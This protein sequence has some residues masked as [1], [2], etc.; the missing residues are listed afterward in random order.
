MKQSLQ[1]RI[2]QQLT[3]TPQLQ[4]AIRLLQLSTLDLHQEIQ[5][6]LDSNLMLEIA[7]DEPAQSDE[8]PDEKRTEL[9][10][11]TS[12]GSQT[13]IPDE[14]P[15][16]SSWEDVYDNVQ[17]SGSSTAAPE[18]QDFETYRC[19]SPTLV[20]HL[21]WQ[22]E[23]AKFSEPDRAIAIAIIDS[24]NSEGY[25]TSTIEDIHL[26]LL[27]QMEAL[28]IEEVRAVLHRVQN[29]DPPGVAAADLGDCLRIQLC[30]LPDDVVWKHTAIELVTHFLDQLAAQN[31]PRLKRLLDLNDEELDQ[32]IALIRSLNP[33]PGSAIENHESQYVIPDVFVAKNKD[34]WQVSLNP[35]IAPKLRV[36]PYYSSMIKRADN[37][38]DNACLRNHLQEARWFLKS[39]QSR[40]D[41]LLKVARC[42]VER[43]R[44]FLE[45]G[46]IAMKPMVLRD[47]ADEVEMHE[48]TIS[49][50]TTQKYMHTPK[51][52]YEFKYFFSS[53]VS[54]HSG[55]ECSSTAIRAFIQELIDNEPQAKPLSDHKIAQLL[56]G[57]GINVARRTIA[58][59]REAMSIPA[60]HERKRIL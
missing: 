25:L 21:L 33:R 31:Q 51:G 35:D 53:H 34:R 4:Q 2:S 19:T 44:D 12:E 42:I 30:Q 22:M 16:D 45:H 3:M 46:P 56:Q 27:N 17:L 9:R 37:S 10:E 7:E 29:F 48:S 60:S 20:E 59:Y 11:T 28:E 23:L 47:V 38:S 18:N 6:V 15:V 26:G 50:V 13:D 1:L 32:V 36:N 43:Q 39:L 49:R 8:V 55:G 52:I 5:Q 41:T 24:I 40:S 58:K 54:T 57:K 14:L